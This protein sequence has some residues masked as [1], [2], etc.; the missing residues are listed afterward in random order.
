VQSSRLRR[1]LIGLVVLGS[2]LFACYFLYQ[3][4]DAQRELDAVQTVLDAN[5]PHWRLEEIEAARQVL[6]EAQNSALL[7]RRLAADLVRAPSLLQAP[8][9]GRLQNVPPPLRLNEPM[10]KA[11]QAALGPLAALRAEAL[12]LKD[13]PDGRFPIRY[14]DR[15]DRHESEAS[16]SRRVLDFLR[17]D[18]ILRAE[19][20]DAEGAITACR[21]MLNAARSIG[22]E[23]LILSQVERMAQQVMVVRTLERVLA[24]GEP[25][26]DA[27]QALQALLEREIAAPLLLYAFRGERGGVDRKYLAFDEDTVRTTLRSYT[28]HLRLITRLVE[29]CRRPVED[30]FEAVAAVEAN[31]PQQPPL[32]QGLWPSARKLVEL[33]A[34]CQAQLRCARVAVA[35]ERYRQR[36]QHWPEAVVHLVR[37]RLLMAVPVDPFDHQPLRWRLLKDGAVVYSV[38]YDR[39]DNQGALDR[40]NPLAANTD[41]GCYLW[42][43]KE[44]RQ[45]P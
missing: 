35:A 7:V 9:E 18:A 32:V 1:G 24:Q 13:L 37:D 4:Q 23:P 34:Q 6:P 42:D 38:G 25:P 44:R 30:Q 29:A 21:A 36:H 22:D 2:G 12:R 45:A 5:D 39:I 31:L 33:H 17:Y 26:A 11:L 27:L 28:A 8:R 19:E 10:L 14:A 3:D 40:S 15:S 43:V 16:S 41:I 20:E